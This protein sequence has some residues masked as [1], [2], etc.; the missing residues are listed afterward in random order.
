VQPLFFCKPH[1]SSNPINKTSNGVRCGDS[2]I[3]V[4][5][6][7]QNWTHGFFFSQWPVEI[8][9]FC[10]FPCIAYIAYIHI[11]IWICCRPNVKQS[12]LLHFSP[13]HYRIFL[14]NP[15][16]AVVQLTLP[17]NVNAWKVLFVSCTYGNTV[18]NN[19]SVP[20][21]THSQFQR[22]AKKCGFYV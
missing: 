2:H 4:S 11:K 20:I 22:S 13:F 18:P 21:T 12:P 8:Y 10:W 16:L 19:P 7:F 1:S 3:C 6:N 5:I 14:Y 15:L 9:L 17:N